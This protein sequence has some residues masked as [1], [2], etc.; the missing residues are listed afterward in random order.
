MFFSASL[1]LSSLSD[2]ERLRMGLFTY[3]GN[4]PPGCYLRQTTCSLIETCGVCFRLFEITNAF[5]TCELPPL[6]AVFSPI[7]MSVERK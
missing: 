5:V 3:R 7:Q 2:R 4:K 6:I 1:M